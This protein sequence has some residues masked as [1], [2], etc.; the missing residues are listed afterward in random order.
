MKRDGDGYN[1][2][3]LN[4]QGQDQNLETNQ[5]VRRVD[6]GSKADK[7]SD[8]DNG[9]KRKSKGRKTSPEQMTMRKD[10]MLNRQTTHR[11][12]RMI[13]RVLERLRGMMRMC[14]WTLPIEVLVE[15]EL[16]PIRIKRLVM[17]PAV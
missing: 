17:I 5:G 3:E 2:E 12:K 11:R 14:H 13:P 10:Q 1:P 7:D 15:Q 8:G 6:D 16:V 4:G 9:E